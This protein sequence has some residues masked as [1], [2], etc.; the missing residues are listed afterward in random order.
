[1]IEVLSPL[2]EIITKIM[3]KKL[4]KKNVL[5]V[6]TGNTCRSVIAQA[7]FQKLKEELC[8][9]LDYI[10]DSAGIAVDH[11]ISASEEAIFCLAKQGIDVTTHQTKMVDGRLLEKSS[12]VLTMTNQQLNYLK[13]K[14]PHAK[15]KV[16]LF[17]PFSH[18]KKYM[19]YDEIEDPFGRGLGF[20]E[21]ICKYLKQDI[22]KLISHLR[23]DS[24]YE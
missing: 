24:K 21:N 18:Q 12:L 16:F 3:R 15:N 23:E 13:D 7:L 1:M 4:D 6:C 8:P 19:K 22:K 17:K 14:Y 5:F 11:G 9:E 20:Y 10:A 2:K